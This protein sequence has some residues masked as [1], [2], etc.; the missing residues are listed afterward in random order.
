V[1]TIYGI[2]NCDTVKK[3]LKW[4]EEQGFSHQFHDF[5]KSPLSADTVA[6]WLAAVGPDI[7]INR[8]GTTYRKLEEDAKQ[9]LEDDGAAALLA[10]QPTLMKRPIFE[11]NGRYVVGFKDAEKEAVLAL[12]K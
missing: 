12:V 5:R 4:S 2:R 7:L 6:G 8:R 1:I 9:A 3:A 11:M 10:E